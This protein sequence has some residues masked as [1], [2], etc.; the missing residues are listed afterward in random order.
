VCPNSTPNQNQLVIDVPSG[1]FHTENNQY[2]PW[3]HVKYNN[4]RRINPE[5]KQFNVILVKEKSDVVCVN[6]NNVALEE[7]E[8]D[9]F[10][11][12]ENHVDPLAIQVDVENKEGDERAVSQGAGSSV[13]LPVTVE[14]L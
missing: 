14:K 1:S 3:M 12:L 7:V 11:G 5:N 6:A 9:G 8:G 13:N 2:G 4:K 10:T